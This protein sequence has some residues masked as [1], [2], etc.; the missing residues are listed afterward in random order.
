MP[1]K[2]RKLKYFNFLQIA[3]LFAL[4]TFSVS[5]QTKKSSTT[6]NTTKFTSVYTDTIKDCIGEEPVFRCKGYGGYKVVIGVGGAFSEARIEAIK[7]EFTLSIAERQSVGWNPKIEWRMANGKP[8]AVIVRVDEM[9]E[10]AEIPKKIGEKLVV[11]GLRGFESLDETL[12]TK[13]PKSN[14]KAREIADK[15]FTDSGKST[16]SSGKTS[17]KFPTSG[18]FD[19]IEMT[20]EESGDYGGTSVFLTES[21]G[22]MF[23]LVII[24]E[25]VPL[26]PVLVEAQVSGKDMR[27]IEFTLPNENGDRKFK[28]V[29]SAKGLTFDW[30]DSKEVLKRECGFLASDISMGNGGD[31]GGTEIFLTDAGGQWFALVTVAEGVL[32][33]PVLV[34][35]DMKLKNFAADT[36]EFTLPN[37][38]GERKFKGKVTKNGMTLT[39][40]GTAMTLDNKCYK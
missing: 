17:Q 27:T 10:N 37:E 13:A 6:K 16:L 24:A 38:N 23:A 28:G 25:G 1:P 14:E 33:R 40:S 18:Y 15:S 34:E 2:N 4:I 30:E 20:S 8:F 21:D 26:T 29:V 7:P 31:Y 39:E 12:N 3:T 22:Q 11:K 5:G 9:D 36:F 32:K 35:V 19:G